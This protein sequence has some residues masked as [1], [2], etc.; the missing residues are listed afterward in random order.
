MYFTGDLFMYQNIVVYLFIIFYCCIAILLYLDDFMN[1]Y[2]KKRG[3]VI[4]DWCFGEGIE[5]NSA[6]EKV[7]KGKTKFCSKTMCTHSKWAN[8]HQKQSYVYLFTCM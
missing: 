2:W 1:V 4:S 3:L 7:K 6:G 5:T 8:E